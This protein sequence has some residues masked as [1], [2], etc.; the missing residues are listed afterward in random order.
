MVPPQFKDQEI[1]EA[2]EMII[3]KIGQ[4]SLVDDQIIGDPFVTYQ[5]VAGQLGYQIKGDQDRRNMGTL[6]AEVNDLESKK[7]EKD[8]LISAAVVRKEEKDP[9]IGF[10]TYAVDKGLFRAY[11]GPNPNGIE[12]IS[13]WNDHLRRAVSIYDLKKGPDNGSDKRS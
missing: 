9:G 7:Y 11:P 3:R 1:A 5:D 8:L 10:Y 6:L 2:R 4:A 12:E 13:F